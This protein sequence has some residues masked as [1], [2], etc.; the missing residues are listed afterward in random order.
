MYDQADY[1]SQFY[2]SYSAAGPSVDAGQSSQ[3]GGDFMGP[4]PQYGTP[5]QFPPPQMPDT[6][7][8]PE[9]PSQ[10]PSFAEEAAHSLFGPWHPSQDYTPRDPPV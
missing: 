6:T 8:Q 2:G 4:P 10:R 5:P 9:D 3:L 1:Y 7:Q